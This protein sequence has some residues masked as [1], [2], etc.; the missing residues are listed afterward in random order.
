[1]LS[2]RMK[3]P[4]R[5]EMLALMV[6]GRETSAARPQFNAQVST[7]LRPLLIGVSV[8]PRIMEYYLIVASL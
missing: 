8:L 1:M 4:N 6:F 3:W 5:W 7:A 2:G